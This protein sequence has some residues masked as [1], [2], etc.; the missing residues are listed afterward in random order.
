M[1]EA[2]ANQTSSLP[3]D[4]PN[5]IRKYCEAYADDKAPHVAV[6]SKAWKH[7]ILNCAMALPLTVVAL[8]FAWPYSLDSC[9][10]IGW[11]K[12]AVNYWTKKW[13]ESYT[14]CVLNKM[15]N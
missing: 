10:R 13:D 3:A 15:D 1:A 6:N 9:R 2:T 5:D 12:R 14:K 7:A 4:I 11:N 8:P